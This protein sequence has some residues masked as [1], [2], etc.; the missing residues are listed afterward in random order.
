MLNEVELCD[1]CNRKLRPP[2]T[3]RCEGC[4]KRVAVIDADLKKYL[5]TWRCEDGLRYAR[6]AVMDIG[7]DGLVWSDVLDMLEFFAEVPANYTELKV[8]GKRQAF[9]FFF[10]TLSNEHKNPS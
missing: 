1:L 10:D 7:E 2:E 3:K 6:W 5:P 9:L 4:C 8:M